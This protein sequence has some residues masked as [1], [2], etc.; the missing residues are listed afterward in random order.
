MAVVAGFQRTGIFLII[1]EKLLLKVNNVRALSFILIM[2]CFFSSMWITNDVALITFV[3]FA[4]MT[5]S[6]I[7]YQNYIIQVIVLQTIAANLGSMLMPIGNPQNLYLYSNF[8]IT[9]REFLKITFPYTAASFVLLCITSFIIRKEP[10]NSK[11]PS[12]KEVLPN[13]TRFII[14]YT[15]LFLVC[16]ATV[17]HLIDYRITFVIVL[18]TI[19]L[20][21]IQVLKR[22]DYSLLLTFLCF[23]LFVGNIGNIPAIKDGLANFIVGKE[24]PVSILASQIISNV[25]AAVLLSAF[26]DNYKALI[27]GTD[28]GGLGTLVASLAS[29]ISYKFYCKTE[30][31]RPG[32]YLRVFTIYNILF[33][34]ILYLFYIII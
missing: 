34:V 6:M 9:I 10:L 31:A 4:I 14:L 20:A 1:S 16:I 7:G 24:L 33:L 12:Y 32:K 27:L 2:L 5:L 3:P 19:L 28:L 17:L 23:F 15:L 21:D 22:I 13:K 29:L 18:F 30:A 26:T 25:P 8:D 11:L